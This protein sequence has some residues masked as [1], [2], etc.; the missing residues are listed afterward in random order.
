[1]VH[2]VPICP[3]VSGVAQN[4]AGQQI[5]GFSVTAKWKVLQHL[6]EAVTEPVNNIASYAPTIPAED[7]AFVPVKQSF[8]EGFERDAFTGID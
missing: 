1:M 3:V 2:H 7:A 8:A 4:N 5:A 6:E